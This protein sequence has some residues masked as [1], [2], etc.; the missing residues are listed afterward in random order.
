MTWLDEA[1]DRALAAA[2]PL[3][4]PKITPSHDGPALRLIG[5]WHD[6][7]ELGRAMQQAAHKWRAKG[8]RIVRAD[9]GWWEGGAFCA[10]VD[11]V[12]EVIGNE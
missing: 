11:L 3:S 12:R 7:E 8:Y 2:P 1:R 5:S 10:Q 9:P 6:E 4:G